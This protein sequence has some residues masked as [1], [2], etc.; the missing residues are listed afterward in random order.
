MLFKERNKIIYKETKNFLN[1]LILLFFSIF[2]FFYF[3]TLDFF[4]PF[5]FSI[6]LF[7]SQFFILLFFY[8]F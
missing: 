7:Y 8:L 1:F 4:I 3:P 2:I 6:C 5:L